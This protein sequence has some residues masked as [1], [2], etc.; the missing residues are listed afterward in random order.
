MHKPLHN[1]SVDYEIKYD[2]ILCSQIFIVQNT[3]NYRVYKVKL[4]KMS[5]E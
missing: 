2:L 3:E 1:R 4:S 5:Y